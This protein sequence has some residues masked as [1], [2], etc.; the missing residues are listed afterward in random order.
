MP[1][2][3]WKS[4]QRKQNRYLGGDGITAW[5]GQEGVDS[6]PRPYIALESKHRKSR[7][8]WLWDA[9]LQA[10]DGK[11]DNQ[12]PIVMWHFFNEPMKDDIVCIR[13]EDFRRLLN[14][15]DNANT[16]VMV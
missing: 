2:D 15:Y 5:R 9:M 16:G 14:M 3:L 1:E 10:Q 12:V 11:T 6:Y 7:P 4:T 8:S 13:A